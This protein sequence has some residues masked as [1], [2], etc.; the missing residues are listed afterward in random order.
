MELGWDPYAQQRANKLHQ[1]LVKGEGLKFTFLDDKQTTPLSLEELEK[2]TI[3]Y[4][5]DLDDTI[6][7]A[8][9]SYFSEDDVV[10]VGTSHIP[11]QKSPR[12]EE[13]A[14]DRLPYS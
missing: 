14:C 1:D 11:N 6:G 4:D 9:T 3:D 5:Q 10:E 2:L 13:P 12:S 8:P 7:V